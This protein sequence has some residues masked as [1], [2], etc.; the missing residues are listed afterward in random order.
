MKV[1]WMA[2]VLVVGASMVAQPPQGVMG[3]VAAPQDT[4]QNTGPT[5]SVTGTVILGDTQHPARFVS[6]TL[7]PVAAGDDEPGRGPMR[8]F[9]G[10]MT[11]R[12][13]ADGAFT[14]PS[15]GVGD[16]YVLATALGYVSERTMLQTA[17][18]AGASA[19]DLAALIPVVHVA[20]GGTASAIVTL[21]K[22]ATIAGRLQW[23]DG[24]AAVAVPMLATP[25]TQ[26]PTMPQPF[27]SIRSYTTTMNSTDDRGAFRIT[28]LPSGDY[29]VSATISLGAGF[30]NIGGRAPGFVAP[31]RIYVPGVFRKTEAKPVT[32]RA[33]D[34]RSDLR[35]VLDLSALRTVSGHVGSAVAGQSV[36][37]GRA[38]LVDSVDGSL[39]PSGSIGAN[40]DFS[41]PYVPPGTYKLTVQGS[42]QANA[43]G[44]RGRGG[45]G[46][47][48]SFQVYTQTLQVGDAN[49]TGLDINLT[50]Q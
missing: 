3:G 29:F 24:S 17:F 27:S 4:Q 6:V 32:V 36:V 25:A 49:V 18:N 40:G 47:G 23:E 7:Q 21:Q 5:G 31:L 2:G 22:G 39:Q 8:Q 1:L 9:S 38:W 19:A 50:P 37:S 15:V 46:A 30:D 44:Y 20:A 14:M 10:S 42:S 16:Y 13:G 41:I 28:G 26:P 33:G 11:A 48:V 43:G 35:M 45:S 12:T 34:E